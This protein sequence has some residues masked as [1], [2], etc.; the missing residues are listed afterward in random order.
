[1]PFCTVIT[2]MDG[3]IQKPMMEFVL[4][5][6]GYDLP[7][8]ITDP[9]PVKALSDSH[10]TAYFD[11]IRE[12]IDISVQVHGSRHIFVTGHHNCAGNPVSREVQEEQLRLAAGRLR[13]AYSDCDVDIVYINDQWQCD[14]LREEPS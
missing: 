6:Y 13:A 8:T 11:R 1:M 14:L 5:E 3:R 10:A 4:G 2:C 7:D 9:G 12:R